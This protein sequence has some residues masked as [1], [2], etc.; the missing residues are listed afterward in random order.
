MRL[1]RV[2][3]RAVNLTDVPRLTVCA[4]CSLVRDLK[5]IITTLMLG[6]SVYLKVL[7]FGYDKKSFDTIIV[8]NS[9]ILLVI[10]CCVAKL[11]YMIFIVMPCNSN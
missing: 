5:H 11:K 9:K 2:Q 7:Y 10:W 3:E 6:L 4:E 8:L 1:N